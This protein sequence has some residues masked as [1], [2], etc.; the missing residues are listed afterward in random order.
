MQSSTM[1][2]WKEGFQIAA[3]SSNINVIDIRCNVI[4]FFIAIEIIATN[5]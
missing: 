1:R 4:V 5:I 2:L 3:T